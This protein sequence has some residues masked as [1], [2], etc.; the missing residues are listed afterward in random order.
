MKVINLETWKGKKHYLWFKK[1]E[2]PCYCFNKNLDVTNVCEFTK[3][4]NL[5]FF[6]TLLYLFT[7]ALNEVEEM[8]LREVNGEIVLYDVIHPAYTVMTD[9]GVFE[10]C[11][12]EFNEDFNVFY[13]SAKKAIE[14]VKKGTN[15]NSYNDYSRLD[16]YYFTCVH[17]TSFTSATHPVIL[18]ETL[19][20][21]RIGWCK[22]EL[23]NGRM[24]M[25]ISFGVYHALVDGYPLCMAINKMQEYLD[26]VDK[27]IKL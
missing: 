18:D 23:I 3:K 6:I 12:N 2:M 15:N 24:Q 9:E 26:K 13:E 14:R 27:I 5:S 19:S 22:Y 1:Y 10:N 20:V 17:W 7:K 21:P 16:Q 11:D 25:A 4:N 8:K